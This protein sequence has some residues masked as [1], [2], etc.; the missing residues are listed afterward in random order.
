S[1]TN[2]QPFIVGL[3]N[4]DMTTINAEQTFP[5]LFFQLPDISFS[6]VHAKVNY[7][8]AYVMINGFFISKYT[9]KGK[10]KV[11]QKRNKSQQEDEDEISNSSS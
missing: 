4:N 11:V 5:N 2:Q 1:Q 8:Q 9:P 3:G 7:R 10:E 6:N